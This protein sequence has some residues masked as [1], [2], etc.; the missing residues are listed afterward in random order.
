MWDAK[1]IIYLYVFNMYSLYLFIDSIIV[2][3]CTLFEATWTKPPL[4][5]Q[6]S[7]Y[8]VPLKL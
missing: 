6:V 3:Q 1:E 8:M 5:I 2:D 7:T 4:E